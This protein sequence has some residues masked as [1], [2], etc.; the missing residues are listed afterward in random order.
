MDSRELAGQI[1]LLYR[2]QMVAPWTGSLR[3]TWEDIS[4][5]A[6]A[7]SVSVRDLRKARRPL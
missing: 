1:E 4:P 2:G 3:P 7:L 6:T 5:A